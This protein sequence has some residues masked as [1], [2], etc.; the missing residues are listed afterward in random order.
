MDMETESMECSEG[1]PGWTGQ[2]QI[3]G[4]RESDGIGVV[5]EQSPCV[6]RVHVCTFAQYVREPNLRDELH[7]GPCL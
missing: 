1:V 7:R 4:V 6:T 5:R 2:V 3:S